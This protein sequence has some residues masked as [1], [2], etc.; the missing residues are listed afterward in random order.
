MVLLEKVDSTNKKS[1]ETEQKMRSLQGDFK[2]L[3]V[4]KAIMEKDLDRLRLSRN[5]HKCN[6]Q[7]QRSLAVDLAS[8]LNMIR[9]RMAPVDVS[10]NVFSE[11]NAEELDDIATMAKKRKSRLAIAG[12]GRN[13]TIG[14]QSK[15]C[16]E[17][18]K[19]GDMFQDVSSC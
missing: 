8:C 14:E 4:E 6:A 11:L 3:G 12:E 18:S 2:Q 17:R 7:L 1:G 5:L 13:P 16:K 19:L 9:L 10:A 15:P